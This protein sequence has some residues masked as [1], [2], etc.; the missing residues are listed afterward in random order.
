MT[1]RVREK[2]KSIQIAQL[3]AQHN[4]L[5]L[6][7]LQLHAR[8]LLSHGLGRD[9]NTSDQL[10]TAIAQYMAIADDGGAGGD[11]DGGGDGGKKSGGGG[12]KGG[13]G[14][15]GRRKR[16]TSRNVANA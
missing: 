7:Q 8:R 5:V 4:A 6:E 12:G 3:R 13:S 10:L 2:M 16:R 9:I 1:A 14:G 11:G 15:V